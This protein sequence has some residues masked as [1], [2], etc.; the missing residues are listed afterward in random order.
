M[1]IEY[2]NSDSGDN[3]LDFSKKTTYKIVFIS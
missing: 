3:N 2:N 1:F